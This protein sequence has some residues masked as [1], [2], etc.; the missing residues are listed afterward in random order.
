M[1]TFQLHRTAPLPLDE[2]WRR[3][4]TWPRHGEVVPLTRVI[5]TTPPPTG[6]GT[7]FV[8]RTGLGPLAF[9]DPMEVTVWRPP[10]GG[11]SGFCRLEKRGRVVTGWAEIEVG[12]ASGGRTGV[13]WR[14]NIRVRFL[15]S[16]CDALLA[17][18]GRQVFGRAVNRLL[19][20]A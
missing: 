6:E 4:T 11:A 17:R 1:A 2:A 14:E 13:V 12:P 5:V 10:A 15:P 19:R 20:R 18:A 8:A 9:H 3:L 16:A 7:V